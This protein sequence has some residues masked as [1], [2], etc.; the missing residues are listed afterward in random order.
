MDPARIKL[1]HGVK[2]VS[3]LTLKHLNLM[4]A[5]TPQDDLA[6]TTGITMLEQ[7]IDN[8]AI[9]IDDLDIEAA[10]A[11]SAGSVVIEIIIVLWGMGAL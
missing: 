9:N 10:P 5:I 6:R 7:T 4:L 1:K 3:V 8:N 11:G 2:D